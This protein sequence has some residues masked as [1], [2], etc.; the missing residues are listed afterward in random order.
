MKSAFDGLDTA[1]WRVAAYEAISV[2]TSNIVTQ[3][4]K[5]TENK[6]N[7]VSKNF[8]TQDKTCIMGI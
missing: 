5:K 2:E 6:N 8:G 3:R 1:D 7:R 4:E